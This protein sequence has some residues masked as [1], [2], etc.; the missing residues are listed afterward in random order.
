MKSLVN[1]N[2]FSLTVSSKNE[3][4]VSATQSSSDII[5]LSSIKVILP[6]FTPL[7]QK[8]GHRCFRSYCIA[9][10]SNFSYT[11]TFSCVPS[12]KKYEERTND[13]DT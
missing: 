2:F 1:S 13:Q 3:F 12:L 8:K 7:S 9:L 4:K 5:L 10:S 6:V 11:E